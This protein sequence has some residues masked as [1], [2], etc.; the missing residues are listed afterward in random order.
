MRSSSSSSR[1]ESDRLEEENRDWERQYRRYLDQKFDKIDQRDELLA[2]QQTQTAQIIER[3]LARLD[4]LEQK[5]RETRAFFNSANASLYTLI[6]IGALILA[7]LS[8][9]SFH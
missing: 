7:A 8:H 4:A 3:I 1:D 2:Q 5:P 9:V 6:S